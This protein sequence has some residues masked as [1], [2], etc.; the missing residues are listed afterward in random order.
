M[1]PA[2]TSDDAISG[3]VTGSFL[4]N[5]ASDLQPSSSEMSFYYLGA[6]SVPITFSNKELALGFGSLVCVDLMLGYQSI[7]VFISLCLSYALQVCIHLTPCSMRR[8]SS[9]SVFFVLVSKEEID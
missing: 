8:L 4:A 3:I 9:S 1:N 7:L 2:Y 6:A 5:L